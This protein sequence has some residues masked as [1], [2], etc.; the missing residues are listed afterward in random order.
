MSAYCKHLIY[1]CADK[2]RFQKYTLSKQKLYFAE[3]NNS[4]FKLQ[5]RVL[6]CDSGQK[7]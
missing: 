5:E 2:A 7:F 1:F 4:K 3:K 6:A